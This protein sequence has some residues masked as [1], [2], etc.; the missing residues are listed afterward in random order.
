[1]KHRCPSGR[2][3]RARALLPL[4]VV[5]LALAACQSQGTRDATRTRT[6]AA[7]AVTDPVE[8]GRYLVTVCAC[9]DCHTPWHMGAQ[10]PEPDMSKMLSGQPANALPPPTKLPAGWMMQIGM[11]GTSFVG[12]W[13]TSY[14][15]NLTPDET[16]LAAVN[17]DMFIRAMR[18]GKH[19][20]S[21]RPILPP[22]P[23]NWIGKMTDD[24]LRAVWQY[25]KTI[26]PVENAVPEAVIAG[27]PP[28]APPAAAK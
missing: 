26:P 28:G 27:P 18:G 25:L 5:P 3:A 21:G 14:A 1:M 2:R 19:Y 13:G 4:L 11:T 22:M 6:A 17:E 23:W 8:R 15:A 10:G 9:N 7:V 12:P 20:G 16:G 24:D